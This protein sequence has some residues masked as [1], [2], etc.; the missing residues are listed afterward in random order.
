[1]IQF[2]S[3]IYVE[4]KKKNWFFIVIFGD[5]I[6]FT[7]HFFESVD[8]SITWVSELPL[9][10]EFIEEDLEIIVPHLEGKIVNYDVD[11][12][13]CEIGKEVLLLSLSLTW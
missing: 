10:Y 12:T 9:P 13:S 6:I 8:S 4:E 1:M 3:T 2:F 5:K 7:F 11:I